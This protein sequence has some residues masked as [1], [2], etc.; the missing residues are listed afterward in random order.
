MSKIIAIVRKELSIHFTTVVGYACFAGFA[1]LLG[2]MFLQYLQGFVFQS[3]MYLKTRN[4]AMLATLNLNDLVIAPTLYNALSLFLFIVPFLTMRLVAEEKKMKT[5]ELL[6]SVP[7]TPFQLV[8]GKYLSAVVMILVTCLIALIYPVLLTRFSEDGAGTA[9]GIE[10]S[11]VLTGVAGV[12]LMGAAFA[13]FGLFTSS[14]TESPIIAALIA[15]VGLLSWWMTGWVARAAEGWQ[16]AVLTYLSP[17]THVEGAI[18]GLFVTEDLVFFLTSILTWLFL[19]YRVVES[20][21]WR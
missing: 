9:S 18:G 5:F 4:P 8:L 7:V 20:H 2:T 19:S 11:S 14:V 21:R 10:W 13:A 12:F 15:F 17:P 3:N 1:L 16:R 6:M